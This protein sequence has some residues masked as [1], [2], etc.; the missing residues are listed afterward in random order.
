[1]KKSFLLPIFLI[2]CL[3]IGWELWAFYSPVARL[4]CP[5]PTSIILRCFYSREILFKE[6][7]ITLREIIGGF[8]LAGILSFLLATIMLSYKT[9][10]TFLQPIFVLLQCIPMFTLSPI[11]VLWFGWGT[12]AVLIPT[13][14]T[15]FFPLTLTLYQ[16]FSSAPRELL[17]YFKLQNATKVQTFTKLLLPHSIP[18]IF[19]GLKVAIGSAG[20]GAIAGE[21]VGGN[22]GLGILIL[23]SRRNYETELTFAGLLVLSILTISLYNLVLCFEKT[24]FTLQNIKQR[25]LLK[26]K[27]R[28]ARSS[29]C[30]LS[31]LV[32]FLVGVLSY[33]PRQASLNKLR[34]TYE[35][36]LLL[37]WTPNPNHIPLYVGIEKGFFSERGITLHIIKS[38]DNSSVIPH[39]MFEKTDLTLYHALGLIRAQLKGMPIVHVGRLV[40]KSLG[41]LICRKDCGISSIH[42]INGKTLGF[43]LSNPQNLSSFLKTLNTAGIYPGDIKNVSSDL[44][45]PIIS[46]QVDCIYGG[47][48]NIE[49]IK[50]KALGIPIIHFLPEDYGLPSGPQLL[51]C[52]KANTL[53]SSEQFISL[54]QKALH[55]SICFSKENPDMAFSIYAKATSK[56][57][58]TLEDERQQWEET[59]NLLAENQNP[60]TE[61]LQIEL[62]KTIIHHYPELAEAATRHLE[63]LVSPKITSHKDLKE[64]GKA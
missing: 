37:D 46:K 54:F 17:E 8:F 31:S 21:W 2:A 18:N 10:K 9:S 1:M 38:S 30:I 57:T 43:C 25:N 14:L 35:I 28:R 41:G 26:I 6:S 50:L 12:S 24:I 48:Y 16:G 63:K 45:S 3:I 55:Q 13:I 27:K 59:L 5:P 49:G 56:A 32:C 58:E 44:L 40:D 47:F 33:Y 23:E 64:H 15:I 52:A 62:T 39:L 53:A 19:S 11:I 51:V 20:F 34:N 29:L 42:D 60:L 36:S 7:I 4:V 61:G 22:S